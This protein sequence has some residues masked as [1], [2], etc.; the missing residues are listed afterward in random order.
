MKQDLIKIIKKAINDWTKLKVSSAYIRI[1]ETF[2]N[3]PFQVQWEPKMSEI[4]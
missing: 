1:D 2:K 3:C 4:K